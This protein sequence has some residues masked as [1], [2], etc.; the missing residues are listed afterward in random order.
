[1]SEKIDTGGIDYTVLDCFAKAALKNGMWG[2]TEIGRRAF[3]STGEEAA[4]AQQWVACRCYDIATA[5][6]A[7][8]RRREKGN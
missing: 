6:I 7:E 3:L 8:K 1:M 5:M 4:L 2:N